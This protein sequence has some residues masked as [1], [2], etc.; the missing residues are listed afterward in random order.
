MEGEGIRDRRKEAGKGELGK[1]GGVVCGGRQLCAEGGL[2][3]I[4]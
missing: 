3:L 1:F 2:G 4:L